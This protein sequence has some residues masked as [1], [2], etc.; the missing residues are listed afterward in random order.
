MSDAGSDL[1]YRAGQPWSFDEELLEPAGPVRDLLAT[2]DPA[3]LDAIRG[4]LE[5][6]FGALTGVTKGVSIFGSARTRPDDP[7]YGRARQ[8][9]ADLGREGFTIITGGG[10]GVM[11]AANRGARDVGATSVGLNI[12]LPFE[13]HANPYLDISLDF[14]HFFAR[15][16]MFVRYAS[17][18]VVLPGGFGTLDELFESLTLI[19]TAKIRHF[20]VFLVGSAF[21]GGLIGWATDQLLAT[22]K[23]GADE[24]GLLRVTDDVTEVVRTI[25]TAYDRQV[26]EC[27]P[28]AGEL[29]PDP[30]PDRIGLGEADGHL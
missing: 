26:L 3:R 9:A 27:R 8:L 28:S 11:E 18:F 2:G 21:W 14:A 15:K 30:A 25:D 13:Q 23:I 6:G 19:Q 12:E 29:E 22:G 1:P 16:V 17:A 7:D 10:P 20:P 24:L 5:M 4:E